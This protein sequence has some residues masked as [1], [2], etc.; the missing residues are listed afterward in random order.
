[1]LKNVL[2]LC[3]VIRGMLGSLGY[4]AHAALPTTHNIR[5]TLEP[6]IASQIGLE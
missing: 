6:W 2:L 5:N 1:M 3:W 4:P